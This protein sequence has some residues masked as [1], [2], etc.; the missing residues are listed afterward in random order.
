MDEE[1][2]D[3]IKA[4]ASLLCSVVVMHDGV[5]HKI[6]V[7]ICCPHDVILKL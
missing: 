1:K 7:K 6:E 5:L 3:E 2:E 4:F